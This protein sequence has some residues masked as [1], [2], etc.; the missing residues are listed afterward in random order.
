MKGCGTVLGETTSGAAIVCG[1]PS[2]E[3]LAEYGGDWVDVRC[4]ECVEKLEAERDGYAQM[5]A[6]QHEIIVVARSGT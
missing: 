2:A 6:D 4:M 1:E 5:V 3:V